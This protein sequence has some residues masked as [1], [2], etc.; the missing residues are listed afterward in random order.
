MSSKQSTLPV[1]LLV[2]QIRKCPGSLVYV[3]VQLS[4]SCCH[5]EAVGSRQ[6]PPSWARAMS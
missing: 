2:S 1:V 3:S 5:S 6:F 4:I